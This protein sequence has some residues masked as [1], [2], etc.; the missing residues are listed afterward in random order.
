MCELQWSDVEFESATLHLRRAKGGQTGTHPLLGDELRALRMLKR[1]A[2]SPFIF[3]SERGAPFSV[4]GLQKMIERAGIEANMPF[5]VHPHMLRH[6]AGRPGEQGHR[7]A[8]AA[9]VPR[10]SLDPERCATQSWHRDGSRTGG[11]ETREDAHLVARVHYLAEATE[12]RSSRTV[13]RLQCPSDRSGCSPIWPAR[14][15]RRVPGTRGFVVAQARAVDMAEHGGAVVLLVQL[16]QVRSSAG[17]EGLAVRGRAGQ[18]VVIVRRIADA[19]NVVPAL[20][21]RVLHAQLVVVAV[22][23]VDAGRDHRR[24]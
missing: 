19:G 7:H 16:L 13:H 24:P 2:K 3:V 23:V 9:G 5:K 8:D 14:W 12:W 11:D 18:R 15:M 20:G 6:A 17:R 10:P 1:D 21:Q 22:Q 4:S